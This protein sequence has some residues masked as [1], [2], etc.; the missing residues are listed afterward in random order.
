MSTHLLT[1][2]ALAFAVGTLSFT[3][4]SATISK[5]FRAWLYKRTSWIGQWTFKLVSCPFCIGTWISVGATLVYHPILVHLTPVLDYLVTALAM[6]SFSM[7][8]VLIIRKGLGH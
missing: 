3:A 2:A 6:S 5:P 7:T 4:S 8:A 1:F